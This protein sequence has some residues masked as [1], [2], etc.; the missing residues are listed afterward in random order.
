MNE[1]F[2]R[3]L[4]EAVGSKNVVIYGAG[5]TGMRMLNI[6]E[7][8][9]KKVLYF[10]D[11][12]YKEK[13]EK[14]YY[15]YAVKA[16]EDILYEDLSKIMVVIAV[17]YD[18]KWEVEE[19]L[20]GFGLREGVEFIYGPAVRYE[21]CNLI[22]PLLGRSRSADING[23]KIMGNYDE[24]NRN[25][26]CLGGSTTDH[27]FFGIKS[28][29]ECLCDLLE[30]DHIDLNILNG[31]MTAYTSSQ[32]LLKLIRDGLELAPALVISYSGYNDFINSP[33]MGNRFI[34]KIFEQIEPVSMGERSQLSQLLWGEDV[35][36]TLS[37]SYGAKTQLNA[38]EYWYR[39]EIMMYNICRGFDI[40][41]LGILQPC[42]F[43][44][45][46]KMLSVFEEREF[47]RYPLKEYVQE[48]MGKAKQLVNAGREKNIVDFTALFDRC[49][50]VYV[51]T[52][53]VFEQANMMIA[54]A[55]YKT[56]KDKDLL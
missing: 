56:I 33:S 14:G 40:P 46:T 35:A 26:I 8:L 15:G 11:K 55:I 25:I 16:P 12:H 7:A 27:S 48:Q 30:N 19:I 47:Q 10:L 21:Q 53:H 31:G 5:Y 34:Y 36:D 1:N 44:K 20:N 38:A 29:P 32:E 39:N 18:R 13:Q 49:D 28:W 23:F 42:L 2:C 17:A 41:F 54:E 37:L 4:S 43:T 50:N 45:N 24:N 3:W 6:F 51:D 52:C 9:G 22:D